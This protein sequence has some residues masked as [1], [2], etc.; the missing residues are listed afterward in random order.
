MTG[1]FFELFV[2]MTIVIVALLLA[3]VAWRKSWPFIMA[4]I[5]LILTGGA[6]LSDGMRYESGSTYDNTTGITVYDYSVLTAATDSTI[7][8]FSNSYFY[9]GFAVLIASMGL[10][11]WGRVA[12]V[13]KE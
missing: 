1:M 13:H 10:M 3:G 2:L 4:S 9:G 6:L 11:V 8:M 5:F 7:A 12:G